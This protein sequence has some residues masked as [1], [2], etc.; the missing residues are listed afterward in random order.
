MDQ[1]KEQPIHINLVIGDTNQGIADCMAEQVANQ[2]KDQIIQQSVESGYGTERDLHCVATGF[3][4]GIF[5]TLMGIQ[6]GTI[7]IHLNERKE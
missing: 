2:L 4:Y 3:K 5:C 7:N 1:P 6:T